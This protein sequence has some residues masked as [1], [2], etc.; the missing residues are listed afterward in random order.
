MA[1]L[2]YLVSSG[3]LSAHKK[4]LSDLLLVI[5]VFVSSN[6]QYGSFITSTSCRWSRQDTEQVNY[7]GDQEEAGAWTTA[8][9]NVLLELQGSLSVA[10]EGDKQ[11]MRRESELP[12]KPLFFET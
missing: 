6:T 5:D 11:E 1:N 9:K 2:G 10:G 8:L 4:V 3:S 7:T 12:P